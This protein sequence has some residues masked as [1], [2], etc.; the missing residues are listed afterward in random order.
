MFLA[1]ISRI[2]IS[3]QM[4]VTILLTYRTL[5]IRAK[6]I[7]FQLGFLFFNRSSIS[8]C[9]TIGVQFTDSPGCYPE[10]ILLYLHPNGVHSA[11]GI[12][13]TITKT[14]MANLNESARATSRINIR[15]NFFILCQPPFA[16][17][18]SFFPIA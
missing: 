16:S 13:P 2:N 18:V 11:F 10:S 6:S 12:D 1:H 15:R 9:I 3:K 8:H 7:D 17:Y 4:T 14:D 5:K